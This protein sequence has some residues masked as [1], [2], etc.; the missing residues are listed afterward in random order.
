M[1]C[2]YEHT[3]HDT[4]DELERVSSDLVAIYE[5]IAHEQATQNVPTSCDTILQTRKN[6]RHARQTVPILIQT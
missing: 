5:H 6:N 1:A 4:R 2:I 3:I